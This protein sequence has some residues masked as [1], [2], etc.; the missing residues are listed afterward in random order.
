MAAAVRQM[1]RSRL[2]SFMETSMSFSLKVPALALSVALMGVA[3][4]TTQAEARCHGCGAAAAVGIL[5]GV[6]AGAAIASQPARP[7]PVYVA[8]GYVRPGYAY[9]ASPVYENCRRI[10]WQDQY[11]AWHRAYECSQY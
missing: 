5:G 10:R 11:G 3:G 7:A 4:T 1:A 8:P 2:F 9:Y 6:I